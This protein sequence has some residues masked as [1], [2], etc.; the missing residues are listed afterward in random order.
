MSEV[1]EVMAPAGFDDGSAFEPDAPLSE[2]AD[3]VPADDAPAVPVVDEPA[4]VAPAEPAPVVAAPVEPPP[5]PT[6]LLRDLQGERLA[7]QNAQAEAAALRLQLENQQKLMRPAVDTPAPRTAQD[8]VELTNYAN[9]WGLFTPDGQPDLDKADRVIGDLTTRMSGAVGK[10]VQERLQ[11]VTQVLQQ[12]HVQAKKAEILQ[13]AQAVGSDVKMLQTML[14]AADP[15]SFDTPEVVVHFLGITHP[16]GLLGLQQRVMGA[17]NPQTQTAPV[18]APPVAPT[19]VAPN[20]TERVTRPA[21]QQPGL[22]R[23][24]QSVA[25]KRGMTTAK[26]QETGKQFE[27]MDPNKGLVAE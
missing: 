3:T 6:G 23:I 17:V 4:P 18:V 15:A 8:V 2:P 22:S 11:P 26:W 10:Q 14:D 27:R 7:R 25:S 24:E 5:N 13:T 19:V 1:S 12:A 16:G 21:A 20:T 9:A